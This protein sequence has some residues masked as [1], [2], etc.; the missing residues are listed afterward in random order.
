MGSRYK[1]YDILFLVL[2]KTSLH[3]VTHYSPFFPGEK[4]NTGPL[5]FSKKEV[6]S[7]NM[8]Q[9]EASET[10]SLASTNLKH[11]SLPSTNLP[12]RFR[13]LR[14]GSLCSVG[15]EASPPAEGPALCQSEVSG[16]SPVLYS[17]ARPLPF[18][19]F[20][21]RLSAQETGELPTWF[22]MVERDFLQ[23]SDLPKL[24]ENLY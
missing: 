19:C 4:T 17:I 1:A 20:P 3:F 7:S 13:K 23:H 18:C 10:F 2:R 11:R 16:S 21:L 22:C 5:N 9:S 14:R 12:K 8:N 24:L 15:T 6:N